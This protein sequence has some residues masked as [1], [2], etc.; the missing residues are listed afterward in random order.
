MDKHTF[1]LHLLSERDQFEI[2]LNRMGSSH[3]S[4]IYGVR[5]RLSV[6]DLLA[7]VLSREQFLA[8]RMSEI[9]NS[10]TYLPSTS[11]NLLESFEKLHGY[12]DYESNLL[13]Q[14]K[15]GAMVIQKFKNVGMDDLVEQELAA[16][17]SIIDL[18]KRLTLN[19]IL[20]HDFFHR[21][22]EHTYKPYRRIHAE[23]H[24]WLAKTASTSKPA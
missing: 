11:Y 24:R 9:L 7:D 20:D 21:M 6:K 1:Y 23:I 2:L 13:A 17:L 8:D 4:T 14:D 22:A 10:E 19:Q 15:P 12:P 3:Q 18:F 16:F 5:D